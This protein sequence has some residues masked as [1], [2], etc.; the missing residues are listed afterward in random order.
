MRPRRVA[1]HASGGI[2]EGAPWHPRRATSMLPPAA[3]GGRP[4]AR[5]AAG[6]AVL[7]TSWVGLP[8]AGALP[9]TYSLTT[10]G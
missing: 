4:Q 9:Q 10:S 3:R 5:V 2:R 6:L 8:A 7:V 1:C